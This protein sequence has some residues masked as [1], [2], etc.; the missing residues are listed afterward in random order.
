M[1]DLRLDKITRQMGQQ[2]LGVFMASLFACTL[3]QASAEE[4]FEVVFFEV[5]PEIL[6]EL[7]S[8]LDLFQD[9]KFTYDAISDL[10]QP[11]EGECVLMLCVCLCFLAMN[12]LKHTK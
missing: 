3:S 5:P 12:N 8:N 10:C 1:G 7:C 4:D 6:K 9:D 11:Q 2:L